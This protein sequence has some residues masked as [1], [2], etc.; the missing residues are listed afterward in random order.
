MLST[1]KIKSIMK[2]KLVWASSLVDKAPAFGSLYWR[3][4]EV[5]GSNPAWSATINLT[6]FIKNM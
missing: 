2:R 3:Q 5:A 4:L 1:E 6:C